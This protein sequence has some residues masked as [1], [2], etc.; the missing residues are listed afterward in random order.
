MAGSSE[1]LLADECRGRFA[2]YAM[3]E[4]T[5]V[6]FCIVEGVSVSSF[7]RWRKKLAKKSD[8][9]QDAKTHRPVFAPVRLVTSLGVPTPRVTVRLPGG[10]R[11]EV[12]MSDSATFER[13]I[14]LLVSA[15]DRRTVTPRSGD[16][17]C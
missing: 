2:R 17:P 4:L 15:D 1:V 6:E 11:L 16:T 12:P 8:P 3:S 10:T 7:Y 13:T 14:Q 9:R 5:V